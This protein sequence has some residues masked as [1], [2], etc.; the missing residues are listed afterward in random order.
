MDTLND[1]N[2]AVG[3]DAIE[4]EQE[5]YSVP[6]EVKQR[7]QRDKERHPGKSATAPSSRLTRV[8]STAT[9]RL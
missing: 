1:L 9:V 6:A 5:R 2:A 4:I 7:Q 8:R 3:R